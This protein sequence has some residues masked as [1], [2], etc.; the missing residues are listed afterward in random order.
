[1]VSGDT[2]GYSVMNFNPV[3][4]QLRE[5]PV[6]VPSHLQAHLCKKRLNAAEHN[7]TIFTLA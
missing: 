1:L 3:V 4:Q 5:V 2:T 6:E 7:F